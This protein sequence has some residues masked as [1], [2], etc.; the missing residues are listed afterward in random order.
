MRKSA[1]NATVS[2]LS[3]A[4]VVGLVVLGNHGS[5]FD[6]QQTAY[7]SRED[8]LNDWGSEESCQEVDQS[9]SGR[10]SYFGPRYYW[11]PA[12]GRPVV[13]GADGSEHVAAS[14]RIGSTG[15]RTGHT[16]FAGS[17]ARGGFGGIG[18]GISAGHGG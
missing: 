13:V 17:F 4:G 18:R 1:G 3:A 14:A 12:R 11:D 8:C 16:A 6:L 2:V 10:P 15:S 7:A 9:H 5:E